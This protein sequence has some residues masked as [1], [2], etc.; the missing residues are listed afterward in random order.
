MSRIGSGN[1]PPSQ[2]PIDKPVDLRTKEGVQ[3]FRAEAGKQKVPSKV[4]DSFERAAPQIAKQL[5]SISGKALAG[6]IQFTSADLAV[7]AGAIAAT[8]AQHPR[9][10]RKERAKLFSRAIIKNKRIGK[11][12]EGADEAD[13]ERMFDTIAEQLDSSPVFAQLV[14]EVTEGAR[15]INLG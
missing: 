3:Q 2:P 13:L 11:L 4:V 9:A 14:D 1:R 5:Q 10:N 15:K 12:F 6:K 8:L 7:I